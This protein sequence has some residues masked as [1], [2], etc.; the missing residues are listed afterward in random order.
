MIAPEGKVILIPLFFITIIAFWIQ[1]SYPSVWLYRLNWILLIFLLFC[2]Y[3]FRIPVRSTNSDSHHF[4]S[5]ADGKVVQI[6]PVNDP[7]LG[8]VTQISIFLS[9]FNVHKQWIPLSGTVVS[10]KVYP[11]KFLAA[12][13]HKASLENE[14]TWTIFK[15][16]LGNTYKTKQI[17]GLI[18]RRII[19]H[20]KSGDEVIRGGKLG[21]IRFGSR[22]DILIPDNFQIFVKVGDRVKGGETT[23]GTFK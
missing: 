10:K 15:D 18:A 22:V 3:F 20:L 4:L 16:D 12:F 7:D 19:N 21:F 6:I 8:D 11:G 9:V 14:Q 1:N 13:N 5:P 23:I 2:L 17:A